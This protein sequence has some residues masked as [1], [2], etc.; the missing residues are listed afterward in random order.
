MFLRSKPE[1]EFREQAAVACYVRRKVVCF[2]ENTIIL[3]IIVTI[4]L[5]ILII[6]QA[7]TRIQGTGGCSMLCAAQ[8]HLFSRKYHHPH[9]HPHYHP[10]HPHHRV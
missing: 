8:D 6:I 5:I 4:I 10:H 7:R 2:H 1:K 3:I 9:H